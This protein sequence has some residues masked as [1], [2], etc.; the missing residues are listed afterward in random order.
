VAGKKSILIIDDEPHI[1]E[2]LKLHIAGK[3]YRVHIATNARE[4][5]KKAQECRPD[6]ITLD[7]M[8]SK[9][10]ALLRKLK[11][12]KATKEIPVMV[13]T[14]ADNPEACMAAGASR[15][16]QKPF[17]GENLAREV[18]LLGQDRPY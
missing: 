18:A 12:G 15:Y 17:D 10:M 8:L 16:M 14:V 7:M 6:V 3:G 11:S 4:A 2:L 13:V 5:L 9:G 1:A